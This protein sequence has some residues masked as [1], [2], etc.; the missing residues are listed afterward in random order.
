MSSRKF[1][2]CLYITICY[3]PL[4]ALFTCGVG[5]P[6]TALPTIITVLKI[7][8]IDQ[9]R[10]E[11]GTLL[12]VDFFMDRLKALLTVWIDLAVTRCIALAVRGTAAQ[13]LAVLSPETFQA[14]GIPQ[15]PLPRLSVL[16]PGAI[17]LRPDGPH[18]SARPSRMLFPI[19]GGAGTPRP[20]HGPAAPSARQPSVR[21]DAAPAA[22]HGHAAPAHG[23]RQAQAPPY[24]AQMAAHPA[25]PH[26][27]P[28]ANAGPEHQEPAPAAP[29]PLGDFQALEA[30]LS[31]PG[32]GGPGP[33]LTD[34]AVGRISFAVHVPLSRGAS[35]D[36]PGSAG[37]SYGA[38]SATNAPS[39]PVGTPGTPSRDR[40][41]NGFRRPALNIIPEVG[42]ADAPP[43]PVP[44]QYA[45]SAL[46]PKRRHTQDQPLE[47]KKVRGG[48]GGTGGAK[49]EYLL[50]V[51]NGIVRASNSDPD[52]AVDDID[53]AADSRKPKS[54]RR[55]MLLSKAR[56][57]A[58][59]ADEWRSLLNQEG[60]PTPPNDSDLDAMPVKGSRGPT[61]S[62][63]SVAGAGTGSEAVRDRKA[64]T[65][66]S[67]YYRPAHGDPEGL[68]GTGSGPGS[69]DSHR[70]APVPALALDDPWTRIAGP[71][72]SS[73]GS[74]G[75]AV[76]SGSWSGSEPGHG[77]QASA[78]CAT[79]QQTRAPAAVGAREVSVNAYASAS[80]GPRPSPM[81]HFDSPEPSGR[82]PPVST[83]ASPH[84]TAALYPEAQGPA[85]FYARK[86]PVTPHTK[87][88][89]HDLAYAPVHVGPHASR[90]SVGAAAAAAAKEESLPS[91]YYGGRS[92]R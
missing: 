58:R 81:M 21:F 41:A 88:S 37:G 47:R 83:Y 69:P 75:P 62:G 57:A 60:P 42:A 59:S 89:I 80:A 34:G 3:F 92:G 43:D 40:A 45:R 15:T 11:V 7:L 22:P 25:A 71:R 50:G 54:S 67:K 28:Y 74:G 55:G 35:L 18:P 91:V 23:P 12:A 84:G 49:G 2:R 53:I 14:L 52:L 44:K 27:H 17:Y 87:E 51:L 1:K 26:S 76:G 85:P 5:L 13:G 46:S 19:N 33:R 29:V 8:G 61:R 56:K 39:A 82:K 20:S 24:Q 10:G 16:P 48:A 65:G 36:A 77:A 72:R 30:T 79:S 78:S 64:S 63:P 4:A 86:V 70:T 73:S 32:L 68:P 6:C 9:R 90:R 66:S 38:Y 31:A